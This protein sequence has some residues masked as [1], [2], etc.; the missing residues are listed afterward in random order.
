MSTNCTVLLLLLDSDWLL[1]VALHCYYTTNSST[2][3]GSSCILGINF[4]LHTLLASLSFFTPAIQYHQILVSTIFPIPALCILQE[5]IYIYIYIYIREGVITIETRLLYSEY[6]LNKKQ[7]VNNRQCQL[8]S[9]KLA[10][11]ELMTIHATWMLTSY[12]ES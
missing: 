1:L 2:Y 10:E 9:S 12:F 7:T 11:E 6:N 3:S 4:V 8:V 5:Y